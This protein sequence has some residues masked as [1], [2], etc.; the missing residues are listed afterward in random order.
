MNEQEL[1]HYGVLGMKWG[2]RKKRPSAG[3]RVKKSSNS[4][5]NKDSK[6]ANVSQKKANKQVAKGK[7]FSHDVLQY[8]GGIA[9]G[10]FFAMRAANKIGLNY[11][12]LMNRLTNFYV[13]GGGLKLAMKYRPKDGK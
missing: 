5:K 11:G 13:V 10:K 6:A 7:E 3:S 9:V 1:Y 8:L 2:V 12:I 4:K